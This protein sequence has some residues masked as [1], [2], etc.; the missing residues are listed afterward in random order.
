MLVDRRVIGQGI[1]GHFRRHLAVLEHPH[2]VFGQYPAH[3]GRLQAPAAE[4]GHQGLFAALGH[5]EQHALL[6]FRE[7]E[8]VGRHALL[9]GRHQIKIE[10]HPHA[11]LSGHLRAAAGETGGAHVLGRHHIA[12]LESLEAGL[13]QPLLQEGIAHLHGGPVIEGGFGEFGAGKTGATHAI[14]AG[15]AAH[16]HHG[17]ANATGARTH[18]VLGFHQPQGHGIHQG[19]AAVAG[20]KGHLAAHG[21]H[22][23][24]VAVMGDAGHHPFHQAHVAALLQGTK[25]QGIEQGDR[26]GPHGENVPQDAAH[27]GGRPLERLHRRG[28]VMAFDLEGQPLALA[29]VHNAG[30]L[31]RSHQDAGAGGGELAQQGPGVAIA[32]MLRPHH[33]EHAELGPVRFPPESTHNFVVVGPAE[34]LLAQCLGKRKGRCGDH[35]SEADG[36]TLAEGPTGWWGQLRWPT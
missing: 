30:V 28:V 15:G 5:H 29:Q 3:H 16:V 21:W 2:H 18:D 1:G 10:L 35:S 24:A 19:V 31:A 14:A 26:P 33:P 23:D 6:G 17:I 9:P 7:Q 25:T 32:A 20:I 27:P 4:A 11:T 8:L 12:A 22:A 34:A 36:P 13:D